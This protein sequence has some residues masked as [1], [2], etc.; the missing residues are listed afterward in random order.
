MS[1]LETVT[2]PPPPHVI[3]LD[4]N[5]PFKNGIECLKYIRENPK[6][7]DIPVVVL[8]TTSSQEAV[9]QTYQQGANYYICKPRTFQHLVKVIEKVLSIDMW[10][11]PQPPKEKFVLAAA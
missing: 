3:F 1:N 11:L 10:Q 5:M 2:D 4:L 6:L 8:S 7:K 9:D